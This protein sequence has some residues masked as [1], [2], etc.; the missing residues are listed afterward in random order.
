MATVTTGRW[1]WPAQGKVLGGFGDAGSKGVDIAGNA[2]DPVKSVADG[3]VVYV[4]TG[5]RGYGQMVI[6][7]HDSN[8]LTAY[9]HNQK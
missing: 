2:G 1:I 8:Y 5:L 3:K 9:A 7:K 4:G 6:V